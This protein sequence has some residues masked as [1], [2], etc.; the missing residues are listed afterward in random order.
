MCIID[1]NCSRFKT[2]MENNTRQFG[3][4]NAP[5]NLIDLEIIRI[6]INIGRGFGH[7]NAALTL[8]KNL[9][10]KGFEGT[11]D[12]L[13]NDIDKYKEYADP[14][15]NEQIGLF[16]KNL[17]KLIDGF[18]VKRIK[19]YTP[20]SIE[21]KELGKLK[22]THFP[23]EGNIKLD[24]V[25]LSMSAANDCPIFDEAKYKA[26]FNTENFIQLQPTDWV[27]FRQVIDKNNNLVWFSNDPRLSENK[28]I[29]YDNAKE[30]LKNSALSALLD[31]KKINSQLIYGLYPDIDKENYEWNSAAQEYIRKWKKKPNL[32]PLL[33]LSRLIDANLSIND[34][35][36]NKKPT[37]FICPQ[38]II[39]NSE[40]Q[41]KLLSSYKSRVKFISTKNLQQEIDDVENENKV[42]ILHTGELSKTIFDYLLLEQTN[43]PPCVE[44]CNSREACEEKGR[45]LIFMNNINIKLP[46]YEVKDKT[47]QDLRFN[48]SECLK[49]EFISDLTS[50]EDFIN[51]ARLNEPSLK[52]YQNERQ[53][54]YLSRPDIVSM[55]LDT[56]GVAYN[57]GK[58]LEERLLSK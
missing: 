39:T 12:I 35:S 18:E 20:E 6:V 3:Y 49:K 44:G 36:E 13:Y 57:E 29:D 55:A 4:Q 30:V 17:E 47:M 34:K 19:D 22:I 48:A 1:F 7:Q 9:R 42:L 41:D 25:I 38:K 28:K 45:P 23:E 31:N 27:G 53:E 11:F 40:L 15:R 14:N 56:L 32:N 50:L 54:K 58:Q 43:L 2:K 26:K 46:K 5:I 52:S 10:S 24:N 16:G 37:I 8:M 51:R 33:I 21:H